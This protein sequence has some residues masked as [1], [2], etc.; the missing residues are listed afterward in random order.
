M[1]GVIQSRDAFTL[2]KGYGLRHERLLH[3]AQKAIKKSIEFIIKLEGLKDQQP[4]DLPCLDCMIGKAQRNA[5]LGPLSLRFPPMGQVYWD[6]VLAAE[7]SIEGYIHALML[8]D[9][10]T[11]YWWVY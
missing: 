4:A 5:L 7:L 10:V 11:R 6:L 1:L 8:I 9:K 3:T 2:E